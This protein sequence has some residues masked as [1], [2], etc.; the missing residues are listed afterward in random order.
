[1]TGTKLGVV[2]LQRRD[3]AVYDDLDHHRYMVEG[4]RRGK[5]GR[6]IA[7][8]VSYPAV[9]AVAELL[10]QG[11]ETVEEIQLEVEALGSTALGFSHTYGYKLHFEVQ[12]ALVVLVA[13]GE[14]TVT[15]SDRS[16]IYTPIGAP[17]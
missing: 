15:K 17:R 3:Y 1:V 16:F 12:R 2:P 7:E 11:F 8:P 6:S 10:D 9:E 4:I 5:P 14:A 13:R